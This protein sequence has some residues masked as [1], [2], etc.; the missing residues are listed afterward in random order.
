MSETL[1]D[2]SSLFNSNVESQRVG[3]WCLLDAL[4]DCGPQKKGTQQSGRFD[5]IKAF[6]S[7]S[8]DSEFLASSWEKLHQM[9]SSPD[10][11]QQSL[12]ATIITSRQCLQVMSRL[13][14]MVG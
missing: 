11:S 12:S 13:G 8:C 14:S 9:S 3:A 6:K 7:S 10:I 4:T 1:T 5:P 2:N